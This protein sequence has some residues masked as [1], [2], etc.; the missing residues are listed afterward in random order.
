MDNLRPGRV[1][2]TISWR[3]R[4][5]HE[6]KGKHEIYV[7]KDKFEHVLAWRLELEEMNC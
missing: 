6:P 5:S 4:D 2:M 7:G 1:Q 3:P